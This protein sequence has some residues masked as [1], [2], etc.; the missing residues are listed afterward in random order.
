MFLISLIKLLW[1]KFSTERRQAEDVVG[2][3]R[4]EG[5]APFHCAAEGLVTKDRC[6][7]GGAGAAC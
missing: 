3:G 5:P 1:L 6:F 2:E 4:T 7:H